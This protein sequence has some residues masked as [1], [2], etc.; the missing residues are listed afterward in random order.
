MYSVKEKKKVPSEI[1]LNGQL[2]TLT[3]IIGPLTLALSQE[4]ESLRRVLARIKGT[5]KI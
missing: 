5:I 1:F 4:V 3:P 2:T